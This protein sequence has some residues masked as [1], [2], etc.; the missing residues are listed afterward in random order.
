MLIIFIDNL[1]SNKINLDFLSSKDQR[2]DRYICKNNSNTKRIINK[3]LFPPI[4]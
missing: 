4:Y 1:L 3:S 2:N